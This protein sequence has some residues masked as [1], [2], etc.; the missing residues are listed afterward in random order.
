MSVALLVFFESHSYFSCRTIPVSLSRWR[1]TEATSSA[2]QTQRELPGDRTCLLPDILS[3]GR[4][5]NT[6]LPHHIS[7]HIQQQ[8]HLPILALYTRGAFLL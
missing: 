3:S 8:L 7:T 2:M 1:S 4:H 6:T 5:I